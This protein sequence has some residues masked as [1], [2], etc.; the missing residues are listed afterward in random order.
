MSELTLRSKY[1]LM[2]AVA[3]SSVLI[4]GIA[5]YTAV[6]KALELS[7]LEVASTALRHHMEIDMMHDAVHGDA[8]GAL[9]A[10]QNHDLKALEALQASLTKH[11]ETA[12]AGFE[13]ILKLALPSAI[14]SKVAEEQ[15]RFKEYTAQTQE[16]IKAVVQDLAHE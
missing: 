5:G 16:L 8:Q 13:D 2:S 7:Q 11:A 10:Y 3:F 6:D 12:D 14:H 9:V 15:P 1:A 4:L